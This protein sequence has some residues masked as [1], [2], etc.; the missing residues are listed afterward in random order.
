[1]KL[2]NA[3]VLAALQITSF[4]ILLLSFLKRPDSSQK[5]Q[6]D[7]ELQEWGRV[8]GGPP[9]DPDEITINMKVSYTCVSLI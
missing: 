1:M 6:D 2:S 8:I 7:H 4:K 5:V 3:N 9:K